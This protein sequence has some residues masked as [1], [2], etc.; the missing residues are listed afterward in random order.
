MRDIAVCATIVAV[1]CGMLYP[2]DILAFA[3][4]AGTSLESLCY[5]IYRVSKD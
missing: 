1:C 2:I 3:Y 5:V 4:G